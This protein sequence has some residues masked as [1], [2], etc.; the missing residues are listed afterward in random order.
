MCEATA[1]T[2]CA[3]ASGVSSGCT[4]SCPPSNSNYQAGDG[5]TQENVLVCEIY[6]TPYYGNPSVCLYSTVVCPVTLQNELLH[7]LTALRMAHLLVR[8]AFA[9]ARRPRVAH[10]KLLLAGRSLMRVPWTLSRRASSRTQSTTRQLRTRPSRAPPSADLVGSASP[11]VRL[12]HHG[13]G[14]MLTRGAVEYADECFCS[15]SYSGPVTAANASD[16]DMA[17]TG[18]STKT[19]GAGNRAQIYTNPSAPAAAAALPST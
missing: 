15:D 14:S 7:S 6:D 10:P 1:P 13:L 4:Y 18:D 16:C 9:R 19:C 12:S 17:C 2:V 8:L 5:E 3:P 11:Q